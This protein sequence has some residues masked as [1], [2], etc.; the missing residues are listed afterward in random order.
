MSNYSSSEKTQIVTIAG[1][2]PE[3]IK[4]SELVN[5]LNGISKNAFVYTGQHYSANMRDV[6]L[7]ELNVKFDYDLQSNTSDVNILR[8]KIRNLL[9]ALKPSYVLVYGDTNSTLAAA[10]AAK[11]VDSKLIHIE[12]GVRCF[13]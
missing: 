13:D 5:S 2:R 4:L 8:N 3:I 10:L 12:A 7:N 1:N 6:F 9:Y 11:D